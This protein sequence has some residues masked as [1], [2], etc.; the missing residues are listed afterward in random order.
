MGQINKL[1]TEHL[2]TKYYDCATLYFYTKENLEFDLLITCPHAKLGTAFI[3]FDY[4]SIA[5]LVQ[6]NAQD[7]ADF[8][9]I[10]YDFGA[11]PL[12]H[13]IA[14]RLYNNYGLNTLVLEPSFPRSVLDANRLYPNCLRNIVD[15]NKHLD[16]KDSLVK[17]HNDYMAKLCHVVAL[18]KSYNALSIELHTMSSYSPNVTKE[19]Y[20]EAVKENPGNLLEYINLYRNSHKKGIKRV[21]ELFTG[22]PDNEIF[23]SKE[24]LETLTLELQNKGIVVEYDRPYILAEHLVAHYL[25][26]ELNTVCVDIPK[27]LLS[28]TT[29]EDNDYNI[30]KLKVD[31]SK[32]ALMAELFATAVV[33]ANSYNLSQPKKRFTYGK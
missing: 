16:I 23:A 5:K 10:E 32:L 30:A 15:Y 33:N 2:Y 29:T 28:V 6:L 4:P 26:C 19:Y 11:Q 8:M 7:F 27:D 20:S 22:D 14:E 25:V 21:T 18:A 31:Q 24:L 13:A 3:E 12:S 9:S 17:L 1:T